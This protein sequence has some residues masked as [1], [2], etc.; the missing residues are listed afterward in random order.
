MWGAT[1]QTAGLAV[2][3]SSPRPRPHPC[4]SPHRRRRPHPWLPG[5]AHGKP[6]CPPPPPTSSSSGSGSGT[7]SGSGSGSSGSSRPTGRS[8]GPAWLVRRFTEDPGVRGATGE[9]DRPPAKNAP[10]APH[11]SPTRAQLVDGATAGEGH[12][13]CVNEREAKD[14]ARMASRRWHDAASDVAGMAFHGDVQGVQGVRIVRVL[15]IGR[16]IR[17]DRERH[18]VRNAS[19][20]K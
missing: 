14:A 1:G 5:R 11:P 4:P 20:Q 3:E 2:A 13:D 6:E 17:V 10:V 9:T 18:R 19:A 12:P 15:A 7:G 8:S 16:G